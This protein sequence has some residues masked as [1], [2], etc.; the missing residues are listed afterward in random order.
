M[1]F[2]FGIQTNG[3]NPETILDMLERSGITTLRK[4]GP[5]VVWDR[6]VNLEAE[7]LRAK[8]ERV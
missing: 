8:L 4:S 2:T 1:D 7:P 6:P 5:I 3:A